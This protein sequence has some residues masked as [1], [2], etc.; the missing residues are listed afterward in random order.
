[1]CTQL[2]AGVVSGMET[3]ILL[4][5]PL[6]LSKVLIK[7]M[8]ALVLLQIERQFTK[9]TRTLQLLTF[10]FLVFPPEI[11]PDL[12]CDLPRTNDRNY[13]NRSHITLFLSLSKALEAILSR[14]YLIYPS[15]F[16]LLSDR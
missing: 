16:K 4:P 13:A 14:T 8:L 12:F 5:S 1:M 9:G 10:M 3:H 11:T 7:I 2:T 15:S 6:H